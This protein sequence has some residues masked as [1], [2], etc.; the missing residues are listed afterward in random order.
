MANQIYAKFP[1]TDYA[2]GS[3]ITLA[4]CL[5]GKLDYEDDKVG[6]G[7]TKQDTT[8]G[9]NLLVYPY[10][11]SDGRNVT[12]DK[13]IE[14]DLEVTGSTNLSNTD[15]FDIKN[16]ITLKSGVTYTITR[17]IECLSGDDTQS[18][19]GQT[20]LYLNNTW[21]KVLLMKSANSGTFTV[22]EDGIYTLRIKLGKL[23]T[24]SKFKL[25]NLMVYEGTSTKTYEKYTGNSP[26]PNP[27]YPQPIQVVRGKNLF[28]GNL[29]QGSYNWNTGQKA[30]N[31][32]N[33]R[34]VNYIPVKPNTTYIFSV[35]GVPQKYV[36]EYYDI[37]KNFR[38]TQ[39]TSTSIIGSFTTGENDYY[40]NFRCYNEDYTSDFA[41]L[42]VQL[43][44]GSTA[45]S[46]LPYNT[47]EIVVRGINLVP[48][49]Y[50]AGSEVIVRGITCKVQ[51]DTGIK[52]SG[53]KT[54]AGLV[55]FRAKNYTDNVIF[56]AGTYTYSSKGSLNSIFTIFSF[57]KANEDTA[58]MSGQY[59]YDNQL[60]TITI[61][62][63]FRLTIMIRSQAPAD[64]ILNTTI[65]PFIYKG[66][67]TL[68]FEPY[69]TPIT[70]QLS[71]GDKELAKIPNTNYR[72]C[73]VTDRST[74]K[75]YVH[76]AV[77]KY[78]FTGQ[79]TITESSSNAFAISKSNYLSDFDLPSGTAN[80]LL[81]KYVVTSASS[82]SVGQSRVGASNMLFNF[83]GNNTSAD[84]ALFK[85]SLAT[86]ILYAPLVTATDTEITDTTLINQLEDIYNMQS[87]NGTTIVETEGDLPLI[88][89]VRSLKGGE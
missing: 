88:I 41:N 28:D 61:N 44:E 49:P 26:S 47:Q 52:I 68:Q 6:Y 19:M 23:T 48:Y 7:D 13:N 30:P 79:E 83:N 21:V 38:I 86:T 80:Y 58:I 3:N 60:H 64:T 56:P 31:D 25:S 4:N 77:G 69:I 82:I 22:A 37:N 40:I 42:K 84:K 87:V 18:D 55:D 24:T 54:E 43:E 14:N 66:S 16:S 11:Y 70:K 71:L 89:K 2:E 8:Q 39:A 27:S 75:W 57:Y 85:T 45:T 33:Y 35:N 53:T 50:Y 62:E 10:N 73:F 12:L 65:Y 76:K 32:I 17:I 78:Q 29:E 5:K 9:Y 67:E 20:E 36:V 46:Y 74:G 51:N 59:V 63:D 81:N 15:F 72:D 34:N 1:K